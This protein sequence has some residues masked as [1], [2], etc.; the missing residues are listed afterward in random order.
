MDSLIIEATNHTPKIYFNTN[1]E[2]LIKGK[3]LPEDTA[4]FYAPILKWISDCSIETVTFSFQLE[5]MNS[6]SANQISKLLLT[7][8]DNVMVKDCTID[9]HYEADDED[10]YDFGK[11][12]E[13]VTDFKFNFY[14]Y[15]EA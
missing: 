11:E 9:W 8:K 15:A 1:G 5:Y 13:M 14:E 7:L 4:T 3:S 10:N 12:L 6:S 2:L